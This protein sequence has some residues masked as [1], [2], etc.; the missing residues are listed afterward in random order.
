[1]LV[2]RLSGVFD[3]FSS[4]FTGGLCDLSYRLSLF[5]LFIGFM[6]LRLPYFYGMG[7][8]ILFIFLIVSPLFCGLF[9]SRVLDGGLSRFVSCFVPLGT[10]V[11]IAPFVCLAETLS[12]VVR[13]V[14]LMMRPFVNLSAGALGGYAMGVLC[15]VSHWVVLFL[16]LLFFYEI[17]VAV[18]HWFIVY[19]ILS[20]SEEH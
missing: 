9:F 16:T 11:W 12:Y 18:V 8:F 3:Y 7:G 19:S 15:F 1:M 17:F 20:F 5:L 4:M 14:V 6:G 10:P 13:P 2:S